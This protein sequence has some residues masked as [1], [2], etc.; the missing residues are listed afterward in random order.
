[1]SGSAVHHE[2]PVEK[3]SS[4]PLE[5][6]EMLESDFQ[7]FAYIVS[8]DLQAPLR[9]VREFSRL[10]MG[11]LAGKT[12]DKEQEYMRII[13][14]ST[15]RCNAMIMGLLEYSRLNT[16]GNPFTEADCNTLVEQ[17]VSALRRHTEMKD[18]TIH[19]EPLPSICG[20]GGQLKLLF[21]CLIDNAIKFRRPDTPLEVRI[22]AATKNDGWEFYVEDNGI[23][24]PPEYES[25]IYALFR[26]L[27]PSTSGIGV[28]LTLCKKIIERHGGHVSHCKNDNNGTTFAV[29][30]PKIPS[31]A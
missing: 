27:D 12:G 31:E 18:I 28:G 3:L 24:I 5:K 13:N 20:D 21:S 17:A 1:M 26:K 25:Q 10:L 30:L 11:R 8:H 9:H 7:E 4:V 23:G 14:E 29:F 6:Y 2:S 22:H 15:D 19:V 16:R